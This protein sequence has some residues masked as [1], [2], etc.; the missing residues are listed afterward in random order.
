ME[1]LKIALFQAWSF[2]PQFTAEL[3]L[4]NGGESISN[5]FWQISER[6][7]AKGFSEVNRIY[8]L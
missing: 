3:C 5:Q 7:A 2:I 8:K 1:E 6:S 4:V